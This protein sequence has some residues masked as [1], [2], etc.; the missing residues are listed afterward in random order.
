[1][2][3]TSSPDK[4]TREYFDSLLLETRYLD[5]DLPSTE[6]EIFGHVFSTPI[7]TAALSH[8]G[9]RGKE[10]ASF[11]EHKAKDGM[12]VYAEAAARSNTLHWVGMG[13]DQELE[14]IVATG[15]KA[16]KV[17]KP[18]ADNAE[19]VRK[20]RHAV[21]TGCVAV[22]MDIDH[23]Y[24]GRGGYDS[25]FG[26]PMRPKTTAEIRSYVEAA[27]VP[28]VVKG[29][30]SVQDAVRCAEAGCKGIVV[31]HHHGM[32]AYSIPPLLILEDIVKA[33][34]KELDIF[35]DCGI[36]SGMDAYKCLALGAKAVSVGRHLM[37][38]IKQGPEAVAARIDQMTCELA[39]VMAR[40]GVRDLSQMDPSVIHHR[41]F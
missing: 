25:V 41:R 4:I 30:L 20:I 31:S 12:I 34:G 21:R 16:V 2:E 24:D 26:M 39:D 9:S 18:H 6:V 37:P 13:D 23:A 5:S 15:A 11:I 32:M 35:V 14:D 40:T 22:G 19:V 7:M 38:L 36:V 17:I 8:L 10:S 33:V 28:F 27:E 3:Y 1:M 29:V